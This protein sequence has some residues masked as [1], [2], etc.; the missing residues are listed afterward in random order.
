MAQSTYTFANAT[1][2]YASAASQTKF[3]SITS[4]F[5]KIRLKGDAFTNIPSYGIR[6]LFEMTDRYGLEVQLYNDGDTSTYKLYIYD[7]NDGTSGVLFTIANASISA[8]SYYV[9]YVGILTGAS[10]FVGELFDSGGSSVGSGSATGHTIGNGGSGNGQI[11]F[12]NNGT[13]AHSWEID[14]AAFYSAALTSGARWSVPAAGDSNIIGLWKFDEGTGTSV[15]DDTGGTALTLSGS[16]TWNT[17]T[18]AWDGAG[19]GGGISIPVVQAYY[20]QR[21]AA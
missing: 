12:G 3:Q 5:M 2:N 6:T 17:A 8:G 11:R 21:R 18:G 13:N 15:A 10:N 7:T 4:L 9:L 20:R 1:T 14:G 16:G 19:G